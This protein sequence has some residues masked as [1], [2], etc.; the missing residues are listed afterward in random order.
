MNCRL[1]LHHRLQTYNPIS[2]LFTQHQ[3]DQ[4]ECA[5]SGT[6]ETG[7][8]ENL[9]LPLFNLHGIQQDHNSLLLYRGYHVSIILYTAKT[10]C[11]HE[12]THQFI[13]WHPTPCQSTQ[14]TL[15]DVLYVQYSYWN[16]S[17]LASIIPLTDSCPPNW[18]GSTGPF[19][20]LIHI[21]PNMAEF[22]LGSYL[23]FSFSLG[24]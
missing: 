3:S 17:S 21:H 14:C 16:C 11:Y 20:R 9:C 19:S 8:P 2:D 10:V 4:S 23:L 18:I 5:A 1:A 15:S 22:Q 13:L 7:E 6:F 12:F 24:L